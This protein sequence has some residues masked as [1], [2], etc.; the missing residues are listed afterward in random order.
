MATIRRIINGFQKMEKSMTGREL[1]PMSNNKNVTTPA[2]KLPRAV[3]GDIVPHEIHPANSTVTSFTSTQIQLVRDPDGDDTD[4][5]FVQQ[6]SP[7]RYIV[8]SDEAIIDLGKIHAI[9]TRKN[10][11]G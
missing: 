4:Q 6:H 3:L 11:T 10:R 8:F 1:Q 2:L 9:G 5:W 7:V